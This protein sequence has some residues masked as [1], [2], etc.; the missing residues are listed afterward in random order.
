MDSNQLS[1]LS[2]YYILLD[3]S[4][5]I[6]YFNRGMRRAFSYLFNIKLKL[7]YSIECFFPQN[8]EI[9][10]EEYFIADRITRKIHI[11]QKNIDLEIN[12]NRVVTHYGEIIYIFEV[13]NIGTVKTGSSPNEILNKYSYMTS[14]I[15]RSPLTTIL[16]LSDTLNNPYLESYDIFKIKELFLNIQKQAERLDK[17]I[18][19][20]SSML[21][22]EGYS[23]K[24]IEHPLAR[25]CSS[26]VL[27]DDDIVINK[28]H[29]RLIAQYC[30][31]AVITSFSD[32]RQALQHI[33][34]SPPDLVLLDLNMPHINGWEFLKSMPKYTSIQVIVLSSSINFSDRA[35]A[36][37]FSQ[38]KRFIEKPLTLQK[39]QSFL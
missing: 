22:A 36:T 20:I 27:V 37:K 24:F 9:F 32:P 13:R 7:N 17:I 35:T 2:P 15:L 18:V 14:H 10:S 26:I 8:S 1:H 16:S 5:R 11:N 21:D 23:E 31:E 12:S 29:S 30:P 39:L 19:N 33:D 4:R 3:K 28:I 38:I 6:I 34:K 25:E